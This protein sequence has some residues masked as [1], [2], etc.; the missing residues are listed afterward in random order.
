MDLLDAAYRRMG[1]TEDAVEAAFGIYR[2]GEHRGS[3]LN[4]IKRGEIKAEAHE[5]KA[6]AKI[7]DVGTLNGARLCA[8]SVYLAAIL[9]P[10]WEN[11][12]SLK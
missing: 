10:L 5:S 11:G 8:E 6:I 3:R 7:L 12:G 4:N 1:L 9:N 2:E